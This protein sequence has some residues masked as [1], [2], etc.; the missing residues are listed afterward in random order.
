MITFD[1]KENVILAARRHPFFLFIE[2]LPLAPLILIPIII[3][4]LGQFIDINGFLKQ[5]TE[6]AIQSANTVADMTAPAVSPGGDEVEGLT[7]SGNMRALVVLLLTGWLTLVWIAGF[8]VWTDYYLDVLI[9][10]NKKIVDVEQR[11]LFAREV[12]S[13]PLEKIQDVTVSTRGLLATFFH[14]GDLKIQ[15]AGAAPE[16]IVRYLRNPDEI[17]GEIMKMYHAKTR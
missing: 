2:L 3:V 9:L 8:I 5:T 11:G 4:I 6:V 13:L 15:T 12:S 1:S 7:G 10:T 14:F 17:K 16:I